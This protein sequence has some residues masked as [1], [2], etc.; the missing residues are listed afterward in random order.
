MTMMDA[1]GPQQ[2]DLRPHAAWLMTVCVAAVVAGALLVGCANAS[3]T[4]PSGSAGYVIPRT[5]LLG[6]EILSQFPGSTRMVWYDE[7]RS[8][9][10]ASWTDSSGQFCAARAGF[11]IEAGDGWSSEPS[12]LTT[13]PYC[14]MV[15]AGSDLQ[16]EIRAQ[17]PGATHIVTAD[18]GNDHSVAS[19][20]TADRRDCTADVGMFVSTNGWNSVP[21]R[22]I[23]APYCHAIG[24]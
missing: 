9:E 24:Q 7:G 21:T 13:T 6:R 12:R 20:T 15:V 17:F 2:Q 5:S 19:W 8:Q 16:A 18:D 1:C 3:T 10:S 4:G 23:V 22:I 11:N 14:R